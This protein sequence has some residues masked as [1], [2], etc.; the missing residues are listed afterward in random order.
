MVRDEGDAPSLRVAEGGRG[1]AEERPGCR[2]LPLPNYDVFGHFLI[3]D[4]SGAVGCVL[5]RAG[6]VDAGVARDAHLGAD[7]GAGQHRRGA[8]PCSPPPFSAPVSPW[9]LRPLPPS[10]PPLP[11]PATIHR[12]FHPR[13]R[14]PVAPCCPPSKVPLQLPNRGPAHP[15]AHGSTVS[16]LLPA[17][18]PTSSPSRTPPPAP[19]APWAS[20]ARVGAFPPCRARAAWAPAAAER[21]EVTLCPRCGRAHRPSSRRPDLFPCS[22]QGRGEARTPVPSLSSGQDRAP[23]RHPLPCS[24]QSRGEALVPSSGQDRAPARHPARSALRSVRS[25]KNAEREAGA[26]HVGPLCV[27]D[28]PRGACA[29][30]API[31]P[32]RVE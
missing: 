6:W 15:P 23:A 12:V 14:F 13:G 26:V 8:A 10:P 16:L 3:T 22:G 19:W 21:R 17:D 28:G 27:R 24:G 1:Q 9:L 30:G 25:G 5:G 11:S 32:L 4:E 7:R 29:A 2:C 18:S 31:R 20:P